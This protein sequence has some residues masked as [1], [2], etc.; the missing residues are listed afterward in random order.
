M[1]FLLLLVTLL[2][3]AHA[4]P[5]HAPWQRHILSA[6][7]SAE[8]QS[9]PQPLAYFTSDPFLR[10]DADDF[11][12]DCSPHG[13]ATVHTRHKFKSTLVKVGEIQGYTIYDLFFSF[14]E[15]I[16]SNEI[17]WKFI[18]VEVSPGKFREIFHLQPTQAIVQPA[19]F[20]SA[21]NE[22]LLATHDLIPG[23]GNNCYEDYWWF[24]PEGPVR[25]NID[26]IQDVLKSILPDGLAVWKGGGLDIK[27][28][29]FSSYVWQPQDAN[30]CPT[31]GSVEIKFRLQGSRLIPI[32]KTYNP[33]QLP[34]D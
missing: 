18:L 14:D 2:S 11:C 24:G 33:S 13:K 4:A 26:S 12:S 27:T 25:L 6:K 20:I 3:T 28:L 19:F 30:C 9:E 8:D 23:T 1:L 17:D 32:A 21:G 16:N 10:D 31:G 29:T 5:S 34:P 15:H 22:V 7:G